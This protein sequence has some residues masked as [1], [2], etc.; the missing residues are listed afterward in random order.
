VLAGTSNSEVWAVAGAKHNS[1]CQTALQEYDKR[2]VDL[3]LNMVPLH[4][5]PESIAVAEPEARL[6]HID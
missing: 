6:L 4:R 2:T 3:F 1:A 5:I